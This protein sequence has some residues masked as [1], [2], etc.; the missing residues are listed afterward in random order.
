MHFEVDSST[1]GMRDL[2]MAFIHRT[3]RFVLACTFD[4]D[5]D[6]RAVRVS[7][8]FLQKFTFEFTVDAVPVQ[9]FVIARLSPSGEL[10]RSYNWHNW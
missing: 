10:E 1:C 4:V 5:G 8:R 9:L 6:D 3:S 7:V 2:I